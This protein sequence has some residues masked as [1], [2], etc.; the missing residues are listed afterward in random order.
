MHIDGENGVIVLYLNNL[1]R[2]YSLDYKWVCILYTYEDVMYSWVF[3]RGTA[4]Y[5]NHVSIINNTVCDKLLCHQKVSNLLK[6]FALFNNV[7]FIGTR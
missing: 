2:P 1:F 6:H 4:V 5:H 7:M 3:L